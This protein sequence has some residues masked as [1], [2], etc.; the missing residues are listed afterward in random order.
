MSG[1][2]SRGVGSNQSSR[3][4]RTI[5][6]TRSDT[7]PPNTIASSFHRTTLQPETATHSVLDAQLEALA[8]GKDFASLGFYGLP[9]ELQVDRLCYSCDAEETKYC[10]YKSKGPSS[11]LGTGSSVASASD[12][13]EVSG[14]DF[15]SDSGIENSHAE[16]HQSPD[17][18]VALLKPKK[19]K[20]VK[21]SIKAMPHDDQAVLGDEGDSGQSNGGEGLCEVRIDSFYPM[22]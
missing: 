7:P 15:E 10:M 18:G 3:S 21:S 13:S 17:V 9:D 5:E 11:L 6:K 8:L 20:G 2:T 12:H 4:T 19:K 16:N 14:S 22:S 1:V